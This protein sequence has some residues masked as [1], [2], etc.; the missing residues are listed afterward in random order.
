[1]STGYSDVGSTDTDR[2]SAFAS[3]AL[4][5][6]PYDVTLVDVVEPLRHGPAPLAPS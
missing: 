1:M 3:G 6:E 4:P 2:T 5:L